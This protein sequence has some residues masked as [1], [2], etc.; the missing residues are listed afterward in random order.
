L[1]LLAACDNDPYVIID[2]DEP[3]VPRDLLATYEWVLEGFN[4]TQPVGHPTVEL[5]WLPPTDWGSEVF[6]VYGKRS[7]S[8]SFTL[9]GTVTSCTVEGCVYSDRN[10]SAGETYEYYVAAYNESSGGETS[11]DYREVIQLPSSARPAA[12]GAG[13]AVG[14]D[15][16]VYLSWTDTQNGARLAKYI[17]YLTEL[18][19]Q[20]YLYPMGET[21]GTGFLDQRA[22]NGH[23]YVYRVAA[24][25]TTGHVS[26]LGPELVGIARPDVSGELIYAHAGDPT[27]SG[28][29]FMTDETLNPIVSGTSASAH[30]RLES[31]AT[32]W[33]IRPLN[34][35]QVMEYSGRTTALTCGPGAD[36]S[37]RA[38]TVAPAA[39]YT[40]AAI[41]VDA[42]YSYIFRVTGADGQPHYAVARAVILGT[43]QDGRDLLIFD[44]A[45]QLIPNEPHLNRIGG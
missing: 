29:R 3:G 12:P 28:F 19:G 25:D 35:T 11:S 40:T 13:R 41:P 14:L 2:G 24:V 16:A 10:V 15:N 31:D 30:W 34:G 9:I 5:S 39:G 44:W 45:Y 37:C 7:S 6:R 43:D 8:S 1:L 20:S 18:D 26:N 36:A 21:D 33:Y 27:Q 42:E 4:G 17:V 38:A 23:E 22:Q 32:G